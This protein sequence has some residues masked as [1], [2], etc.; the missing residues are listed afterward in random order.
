MVQTALVVVCAFQG[1]I[2]SLLHQMPLARIMG[3]RPLDRVQINSAQR[4]AETYAFK[5]LNELRNAL[6][7]WYFQRVCHDGRVEVC[8]PTGCVNYVNMSEICDVIKSEPIIIQSLTRES[9]LDWLA[10]PYKE[11][12]SPIPITAYQDAYVVRAEKDRFGFVDFMVWF[13]DDR[14]N[15]DDKLWRAIQ[16]KEQRDANIKLAR[17]T[18]MPVRSASVGLGTA[19]HGVQKTED[20]HRHAFRKFVHYA[21]TNNDVKRRQ[22]QSIDLTPMS[23]RQL[24]QR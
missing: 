12:N 18:T 22:V 14:H 23:V 19:D 20:F 1:I 3:L 11:K 21:L 15:T 10:L 17:R 16:P 24:T 13:V 5:K 2:M 9:Y 6:P 4:I 8:T 7:Y